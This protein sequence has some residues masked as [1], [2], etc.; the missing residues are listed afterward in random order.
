MQGICF[1]FSMF[2]LGGSLPAHWAL[3]TNL[4]ESREA[5]DANQ[6]KQR[7]A[8]AVKGAAKASMQR[9]LTKE[10][11][12]FKKLIDSDKVQNLT[13]EE[14]KKKKRKRREDEDAVKREAKTARR[15]TGKC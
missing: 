15:V 5:F 1:V 7:E 10:D 4:V 8:S 3:V 11:Q 12:N 9:A 13:D 6:K 2:V 14:L